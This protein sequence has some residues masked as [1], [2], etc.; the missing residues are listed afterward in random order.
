[1]VAAVALL[2]GRPVPEDVAVVGE[3]DAAGGVVG[4]VGADEGD[5]AETILRLAQLNHVRRVF[6]PASSE[7][8][9]QVRVEE[10]GPG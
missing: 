8:G 4:C 6:V 1:M 7:S 10:R 9:R 3:T 2:V 5:D